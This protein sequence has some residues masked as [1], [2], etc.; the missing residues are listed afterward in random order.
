MKR[1]LAVVL[2]TLS[3]SAMAQ[4]HGH[5]GGFNHHPGYGWGWSVPI[6]V[7]GAIIGYELARTNQPTVVVQQPPNIIYSSPVYGQNQTCTPWTETQHS[8]GSITRTR[9][10]SQ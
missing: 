10:C 2:L 7:G 4:H 6:V 9:T 3:A 8:D 1:L 5:R